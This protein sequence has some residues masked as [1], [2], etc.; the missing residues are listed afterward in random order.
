[1]NA[2]AAHLDI[3]FLHP[4]LS[5]EKIDY[6]LSGIF[7][8]TTG[9]TD[10]LTMAP[11]GMVGLAHILRDAGYRTR[12]FNVAKVFL[13]QRG[14]P[15]VDVWDY[16]RGIASRIYG[17]GLHW[18]VHAPGALELGARIKR[19]HPE[20]TIVFGG[21]TATLYHRD[22]LRDYPFI[23][24]VVI[25]ECEHV[26]V[27]VVAAMLD[28]RA[29]LSKISNVAVRQG[30]EIRVA[31]VSLPTDFSL[32]RFVTDE[33]LVDPAPGRFDRENMMQTYPLIRGCY[34]DC[35]FCGGSRYSYDAH[36]H[37]P[38]PS[39][40]GI[41]HFR[42]CLT[43]MVESNA[44][45]L[46]LNGDT[47]AFGSDYD[48]R[49]REAVAETGFVFDAALEVFDLPSRQYL[50]QWKAITNNMVLILSPESTFEDL[51][52]VHGKD[53]T[54]EDI[55]E[56]G[57]WCD[58]LGIH[59]VFSLMYPLPGHTPERILAELDFFEEILSRYSKASMMFQPYLFIDPGC[60]VFDHPERFGATVH[61]RTLRDIVEALTRPYWFYAIGYEYEG[62]SRE[63]LFETI[64]EVSS[65]KASLYHKHGRLSAVN[66]AKT[67]ENVALQRE[68]L[69]FIQSYDPTDEELDRFIKRSFPPYLRRSNT[70][71]VQRP[72]TGYIVQDRY[73]P[74]AAV[75]DAF[76]ITLELIH[77]FCVVE[78]EVLVERAR[79][80]SRSAECS[81]ADLARLGDSCRRLYTALFADSGLDAPF[82]EPLLSFEWLVY[83]YFYQ[84]G[85]GL[86]PEAELSSEFNF[87]SIDEFVDSVAAGPEGL[88]CR[89]RSTRYRFTTEQL[90]SNGDAGLREV[91]VFSRRTY[92]LDP[93]VKALVKTQFGIDCDQDYIGYD[94]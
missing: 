39:A 80:V 55:I 85:A 70:N 54:N 2:R 31:P 50:E 62:I 76:P 81:V 52:A 8:S 43:D 26:I 82:L 42:R 68:T 77:R 84:Q 72:F 94:E 63:E 11:M 78:I 4:P 16:V 32:A 12:V 7:E 93:A 40:L 33:T 27:S 46:K 29:A 9:T 35:R 60:E 34:R 87:D 88:R 61:T 23:D 30:G 22:L 36:F 41:D 15:S 91:N 28:D 74:E 19:D 17:I 21:L 58:E 3:A 37:R 56:V 66:L 14:D 13:R 49:M 71:I 45:V 86:P 83:Q 89:P 64:L 69:A 1:M 18:A 51:R 38:E 90:V 20:S 92:R 24:V 65:R 75:Y 57:D 10:M 48:E 73:D 47:R 53:F 25:G 79:A 59:L 67:L 6:P 5:F 44:R